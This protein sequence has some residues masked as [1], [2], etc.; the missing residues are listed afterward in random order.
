V[1]VGVRGQLNARKALVNITGM[2]IPD[3]V[4]KNQT[5]SNKDL[6]G[7]ALKLIQEQSIVLNKTYLRGHGKRKS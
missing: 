4:Q 6:D 2:L 7:G 3:R 5:S 1:T